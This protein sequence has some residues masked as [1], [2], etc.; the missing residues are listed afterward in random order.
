MIKDCTSL[1]GKIKPG[2]Q[3]IVCKKDEFPIFE[4]SVIYKEVPFKSV[5]DLETHLLQ[6]NPARL[7]QFSNMITESYEPNQ[8]LTYVFDRR[9]PCDGATPCDIYYVGI[10]LDVHQL[11]LDFD[12]G[13][14]LLVG[15]GRMP[16]FR[17]NSLSQIISTKVTIDNPKK[18]WI[19]AQQA[20]L[21]FVFGFSLSS[22][23]KLF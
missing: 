11:D 4:L 9:K 1:S 12:R 8:V 10:S 20:F 15:P 22:S 7:T 2:L 14:Y 13:D 21:R 5:F 16:Q 6:P 19:D 17:K 23:N 18:L 3:T